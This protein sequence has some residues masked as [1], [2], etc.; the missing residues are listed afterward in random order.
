MP[1]RRGARPSNPSKSIKTAVAETMGL[2]AHGSDRNKRYRNKR[3]RK[4]R[5]TLR[6]FCKNNLPNLRKN[7]KNNFANLHKFRTNPANFAQSRQML[8]V[9]AFF[10]LTPP[11]ITPPFVP[12]QK[13]WVSPL[14]DH[15]RARSAMRGRRLSWRDAVERK[16]LGA[17]GEG[18]GADAEG[19][20]APGLRSPS[21]RC[22]IPQNSAQKIRKNP[23]KIR[24]ISAKFRKNT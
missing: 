6:K 10:R 7:C 21:H 15:A 23:K 22:K 9:S 17:Q 20:C 12:F 11:F 2:R 3:G 1:E 18:F 13:R 19:F 16:G 8:H 24:A 14:T 4:F 5:A